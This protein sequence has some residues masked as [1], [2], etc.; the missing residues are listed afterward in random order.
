LCSERDGDRGS[1]R[2]LGER[3]LERVEGEV[4][5]VEFHIL[6]AKGGVVGRRAG[7]FAG[8][9]EKLEGNADEICDGTA[10][11]G[12][13]GVGISVGKYE[14]DDDDGDGFHSGRRGIFFLVAGEQA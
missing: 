6:E 14:H 12:N 5:D 9:K 4:I 1:C 3:G 11:F 13:G 2:E 7:I 10:V 8:S